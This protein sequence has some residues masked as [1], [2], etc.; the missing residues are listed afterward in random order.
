MI[1]LKSKVSMTDYLSVYR[2]DPETGK[3]TLV[4]QKENVT[5][6]A[7]KTRVMNRLSLAS[8]LDIIVVTKMAW[9]TGTAPAA[10]SDVDLAS[11]ALTKDL[12]NIPDVSGDTIVY[13][14]R[15]DAPE[16]NVNIRE[17]GLKTSDNLL[18]ARVNVS[19]DKVATEILIFTWTKSVLGA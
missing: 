11:I 10:V 19:I 4:C 12:N 8:N 13:E 5:I 18:A 15:L 3:R 6:T 7:Y 17:V 16:G 2:E 9:G 1:N 14:G